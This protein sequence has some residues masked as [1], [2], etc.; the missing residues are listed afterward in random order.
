MVPNFKVGYK[1]QIQKE[2]TSVIINRRCTILHESIDH[3]V[4][5]ALLMTDRYIAE[6]TWSFFPTYYI[7]VTC[8]TFSSCMLFAVQKN[9]FFHI[10]V[11]ECTRALCFESALCSSYVL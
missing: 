11:T 2:V 7:M 5:S 6:V 3:L 10:Q 1:S 4:W 9:L 8:F